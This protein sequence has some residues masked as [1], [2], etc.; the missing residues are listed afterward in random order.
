[1]QQRICAKLCAKQMSN[2][3]YKNI[4]AFLRYSEFRVET[5]CFASPCRSVHAVDIIPTFC[6]NSCPS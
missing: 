2:I 3:W 6:P 1:M 4:H 5:F